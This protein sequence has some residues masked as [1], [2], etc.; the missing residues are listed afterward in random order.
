MQVPMTPTAVTVD[1]LCQP[2]GILL[3]LRGR[4]EALATRL[5]HMLCSCTLRQGECRPRVIMH[6]G[7][8]SAFFC[9]FPTTVFPHGTAKRPWW[10]IAWGRANGVGGKG[11]LRGGFWTV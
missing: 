1:K 8:P 6:R 11:E 2:G 4:I 5:C 3:E 10:E 7:Q 9:Y